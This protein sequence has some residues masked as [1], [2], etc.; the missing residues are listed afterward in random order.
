MG[1]RGHSTFSV[2]PDSEKDEKVECP[3]FL[4]PEAEETKKKSAV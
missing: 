3:L 4:F 1:K 2:S